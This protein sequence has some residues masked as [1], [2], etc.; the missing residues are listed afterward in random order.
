M[1][2]ASSPLGTGNITPT[3]TSGQ[4]FC[5]V[6][7]FLGIPVLSL[8]F[9]LT[10]YYLTQL[11]R[12]FLLK[13]EQRFFGPLSPSHSYSYNIFPSFMVKNSKF[14]FDSLLSNP[15]SLTL[16]PLCPTPF[17]SFIQFPSYYSLPPQV[18]TVFNTRLN[19]YCK[20]CLA[21]V[22]MWIIGN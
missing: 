19:I 7:V 21:L 6:Y 18:E 8:F 22:V 4:W 16:S 12:M 13:V 9:G 2:W 10:G 3:T 20:Q 17:I 14:C 15:K 11:I 5:I 1:Q